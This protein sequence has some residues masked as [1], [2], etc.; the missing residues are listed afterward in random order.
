MAFPNLSSFY[1][2][3]MQTNTLGRSDIN[4]YFRKFSNNLTSDH[5]SLLPCIYLLFQEINY[6]PIIPNIKRSNTTKT[7]TF[8]FITI[9][10][11]FLFYRTTLI[12]HFKSIT[13]ILNNT[14]RK[15]HFY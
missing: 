7:P 9:C 8:S 12:S 13:I 11:N 1:Y 14:Y 5:N 4:P 6:I 10:F 3:Q 2:R 15:A